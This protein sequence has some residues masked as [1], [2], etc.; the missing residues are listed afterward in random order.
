MSGLSTNPDVTISAEDFHSLGVI[1]KIRF[2][3]RLIDLKVKSKEVKRQLGL[4]T[5]NMSHLMRLSKGLTED[6]KNIIAKGG[7][8]AGH[9]RAIARL[10]KP[11]QERFTRDCIQKKW[12]VRKIEVAV[13]ASLLGVNNTDAEY[14]RRLAETVGDQIGHPVEIHPDTT[15]VG[16][17]TIVIRYLGLEAFEGI[18]QRMRVKLPD[19]SW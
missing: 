9:A 3:E 10:S 2:V 1:E 5:Y 19:E 6:V 8:S 13:K 14:Y 12:S 7:L 15:K 18:L 17:G 16:Q 4:T 11:L